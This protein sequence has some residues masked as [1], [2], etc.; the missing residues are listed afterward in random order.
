MIQPTI[1]IL[2]LKKG[3]LRAAAEPI[4]ALVRLIAP[5]Q[6]STHSAALRAPLD[7]V[8]VIDRSGR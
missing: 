2:A 8:L 1:E 6:P 7:L 3:F 5:A 4:H